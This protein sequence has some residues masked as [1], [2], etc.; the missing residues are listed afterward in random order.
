MAQEYGL[1]D[2]AYNPC[3][4]FNS[5]KG[6]CDISQEELGVIQILVKRFGLTLVKA[7][8]VV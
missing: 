4:V 5:S 7:A 1:I 8:K 3:Q 6:H 2:I